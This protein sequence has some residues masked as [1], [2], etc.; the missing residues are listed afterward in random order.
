MSYREALTIAYPHW[1]RGIAKYHAED[2]H[3]LFTE[4]FGID[5]KLNTGDVIEAGCAKL[6]ALLEK[7]GIPMSLAAHGA[8]PDRKYILGALTKEDFGEFS[9][10]EMYQMVS[11]CYQQK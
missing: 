1:L 10:E 9:V 2:I 8:C 11:A 5:D 3:A 4:V 6:N 7:S